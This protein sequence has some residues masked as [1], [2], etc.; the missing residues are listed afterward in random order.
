LA[1]RG[2]FTVL[3]AGPGFAEIAVAGTGCRRYARRVTTSVTTFDAVAD[4]GVDSFG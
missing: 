4:G 2:L 3:A 1:Q